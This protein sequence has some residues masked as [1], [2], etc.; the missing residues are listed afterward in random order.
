MPN[1]LG[2]V[3]GEATILEALGV[4][5]KDARLG[6]YVVIEYDGL[7]TLGLV[8]SVT[9]GSR[10]IDENFT[11][12]GTLRQL[13]SMTNDGLEYL[14]ARIKLVLD[15]NRGVQ[16]DLPPKPGAEI[17]LATDTEL[18]PLFSPAPSEGPI[19]IGKVAGTNI[20]VRL[21][22]RYLSTRHLAILAA[23]GAGK[24]NTVA[25]LSSGIADQGGTVVIY[26]YHGEYS[27]ST[28]PKLNVIDVKLNP[29]YM[30]TNELAELMD[31]R[32]N[33]SN[34]LRILRKAYNNVKKRLQEKSGVPTDQSF[35]SML[36]EEVESLR[37]N[38]D[39]KSADG[40]LNKLDDL[41]ERFRDI[42][43]WDASDVTLK[44]KPGHVNVIPLNSLDE[45]IMDAVISHYL[46]S[47]LRS[48]KRYKTL[49]EGLS[50]PVINV[51][52]EAHVFISKNEN[53][54][55]KF[56]ASKVAKEGRKFGVSLVVVS[57]RPKGLD[58]NILSQMV[59]KIILRIVEPKDKEYV[60]QSS[61]N[62]SE[63]LVDQLPSLRVGQALIVGMLVRAPA[64]VEINKF[65]GIL[66]GAD[67]D[68]LAEIRRAE[69]EMK[70][71]KQIGE[72]Y[73][74]MEG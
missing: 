35:T 41:D 17:R 70:Q 25:V 50:F 29:L 21:S 15:L 36:S 42:F 51:I 39:K 22:L 27:N 68:I 44:L 56:W 4:M 72:E 14:T 13:L 53:I 65:N 62:L 24:S 11:D 69:E 6:N 5:T 52:E 1:T 34:Q 63:D 38:E 32:D 16:P 71:R 7:K 19:E 20:P 10:M 31:I 33:A 43:S 45:N 18:S 64:I 74:S 23:T 2:Y 57:Q 12:I 59:N 61:D 48:R 9:R 28:I 47:I 67:P 26:D 30:T 8:T 54:L 46:S 37:D 73:A 40:L 55:A 3:I 58:D 60:L 66:G 49:G